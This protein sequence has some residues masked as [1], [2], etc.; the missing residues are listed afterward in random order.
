MLADIKCKFKLLKTSEFHERD[1]NPAIPLD[2]E[3]C[4]MSTSNFKEKVEVLNVSYTR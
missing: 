2:T 4:K 3:T 1:A